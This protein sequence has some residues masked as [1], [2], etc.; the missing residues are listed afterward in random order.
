MRDTDT[1][2]SNCRTERDES[3]RTRV[4]HLNV[5]ATTVRADAPGALDEQRRAIVEALVEV[6]I[7]DIRRSTS[8]PTIR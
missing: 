8:A 7:A 6:V 1:R 5:V 2:R 4:D 3:A